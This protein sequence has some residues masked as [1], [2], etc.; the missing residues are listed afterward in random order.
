[1]RAASARAPVSKYRDQGYVV[2]R[3]TQQSGEYQGPQLRRATLN[4]GV[5]SAAECIA[6]SKKEAG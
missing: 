5:R 6:S 3:T 1:M 4:I 2:T